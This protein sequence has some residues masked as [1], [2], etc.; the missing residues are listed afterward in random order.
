MLPSR[1]LN[2]QNFSPLSLG[3]HILSRRH[4]CSSFRKKSPPPTQSFPPALPAVVQ[5]PP[6]RAGRGWVGTGTTALE[7]GVYR[8]RAPGRGLAS[9][10]PFTSPVPAWRYPRR[11]HTSCPVEPVWPLPEVIPCRSVRT[12]LFQVS[13]LFSGFL[14]GEI[15]A[16]TPLPVFFFCQIKHTNHNAVSSTGALG[17]LKLRLFRDTRLA[18]NYQYS[19]GHTV[20]FRV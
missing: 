19:Q 10:P 15:D 9:L 1:R 12:S 20:P 11:G 7:W 18:L 8:M 6:G 14:C 4:L 2:M 17:P 5:A 3:A 13:S 16:S